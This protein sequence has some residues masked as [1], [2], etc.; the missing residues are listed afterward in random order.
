MVG[1]ATLKVPKR[2]ESWREGPAVLAGCCI[3]SSA[4]LGIWSSGKEQMYL[5]FFGLGYR[6]EIRVKQ[7]HVGNFL[8][9]FLGFH[10]YIY[11]S[12]PWY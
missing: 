9:G 2:E 4:N 12:F 1:I 11:S 5:C 10:W 7:T 8:F 6:F 3:G